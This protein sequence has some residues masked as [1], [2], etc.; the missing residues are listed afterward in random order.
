MAAAATTDGHGGPGGVYDGPFD[1]AH[2]LP[3]F[4]L[5]AAPAVRALTQVPHHPF[6]LSFVHHLLA[7]YTH[8]DVPLLSPS[9]AIPRRPTARCDCVSGKKP[10]PPAPPR[11]G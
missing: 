2:P 8:V 9:A 1:A 5:G 10:A 6:D 11:R 7:L 3:P 4:A